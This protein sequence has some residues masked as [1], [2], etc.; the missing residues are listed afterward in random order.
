M[1]V[2]SSSKWMKNKFQIQKSQGIQRKI[3]MKKNIP[4]FIVRLLKIEDTDNF[5]F[6]QQEQLFYTE[7]KWKQ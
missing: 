5:F 6:S 4:G 3:I 2:K 1:T 7:E